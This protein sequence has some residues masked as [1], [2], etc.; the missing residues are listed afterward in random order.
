VAHETRDRF[1]DLPE[2]FFPFRVEFVE[3]RTGE[4]VQVIDVAGPGVLV[5]PRLGDA[6]GPLKTR[7]TWGTGHVTECSCPPP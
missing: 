2:S 6:Y 3:L 5:V 1:V 7:I 4:T